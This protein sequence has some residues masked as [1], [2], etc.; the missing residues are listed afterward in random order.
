MPDPDDAFRNQLS[1]PLSASLAEARLAA[2]VDSADDG[3]I[4]KTLDGIVTSW[5]AAA[6]RIFGYSAEEMVGSSIYRLIPP[7]LRDEEQMTGKTA[8][9]SPSSSRSPRC[10]T[11][12]A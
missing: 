1:E 8:P 4:S 5:N 11:L 7:D 6:E 12:P 3:I 9:G 10:A 2:I